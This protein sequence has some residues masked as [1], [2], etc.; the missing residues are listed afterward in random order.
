M[1]SDGLPMF[2]VTA[3]GVS[4]LLHLIATRSPTLKPFSMS[5]F[6]TDRLTTPLPAAPVV[7]VV[8]VPDIWF[9]PVVVSLVVVVVVVLLVVPAVVSDPLSR[10]TVTSLA[11]MSTAVTVPRSFWSGV[12]MCV[13][14]S[15]RREPAAG[16]GTAAAINTVFDPIM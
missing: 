16:A 7:V 1:D 3:A 11:S 2:V 8:V 9:A 6:S 10:R 5:P 14:S 15:A 4:W 13:L 12:F